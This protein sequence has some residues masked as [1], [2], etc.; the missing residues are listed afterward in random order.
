MLSCQDAEARLCETSA[1]ELPASRRLGPER[2]RAEGAGPRT[3]ALSYLAPS[4]P[5]PRAARRRAGCQLPWQ[6]SRRVFLRE[7]LSAG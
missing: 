1:K 7:L 2:A 6:P 5:T 4:R 3:Y